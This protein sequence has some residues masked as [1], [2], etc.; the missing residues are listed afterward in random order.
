[1]YKVMRN[2]D[3]KDLL[4]K[5]AWMTEKNEKYKQNNRRKYEKG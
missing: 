3:D 5:G 2:M 4:D 1:M